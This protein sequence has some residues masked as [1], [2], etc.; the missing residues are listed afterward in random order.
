MEY[1]K[2]SFIQTVSSNI[3]SDVDS[4]NSRLDIYNQRF[5]ESANNIITPSKDVMVTDLAER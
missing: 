3:I 4:Y 5:I 1:M 2:P